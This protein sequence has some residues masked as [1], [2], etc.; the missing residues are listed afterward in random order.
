MTSRFWFNVQFNLAL[1][2]N[3]S[4]C[5]RS[6]ARSPLGRLSVQFG[7]QTVGNND[8]YY[9]QTKTLSSIRFVILDHKQPVQSLASE[10]HT[11]SHDRCLAP[12]THDPRLFCFQRRSH[13]ATFPRVRR[14]P[15]QQ[16]TN[17]SLNCE[18]LSVQLTLN[19]PAY[20]RRWLMPTPSPAHS[21]LTGVWMDRSGNDQ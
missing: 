19:L 12:A 14:P 5:L 1:V 7:L 15:P 9:T 3:R 8:G 21:S 16:T 13:R 18:L 11:V 10:A 20:L 4:F 17:P 6:L 2:S